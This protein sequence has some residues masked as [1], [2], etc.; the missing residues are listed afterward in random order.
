MKHR[1]KFLLSKI[2]YYKSESD[3]SVTMYLREEAIKWACVLHDPTCLRY[4]VS[5]LHRVLQKKTFVKE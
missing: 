3:S 2:G 4:A 1:L 5:E